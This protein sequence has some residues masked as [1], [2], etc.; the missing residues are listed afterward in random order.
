MRMLPNGRTDFGAE[1]RAAVAQVVGR[2][3][4]EIHASSFGHSR[5]DFDRKLVRRE[6]RSIGQLVAKDA[7]ALVGKRKATAL[8]PYPGRRTGALFRAIKAR[9]SK[10]GFSVA[11]APFR[12]SDLMRKGSGAYYPGFLLYGA[13]R[14]KRGGTLHPR[15]NYIE[16][17][18]LRHQGAARD[19]LGS[20]LQSALVPRG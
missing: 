1:Q 7:R 16:A 14:G 18:T 5:V 19:R 2:V 15:E 4:F 13:E 10:S 11:I 6:M 3:P 17:A 12:N 20:I 9:V 8:A